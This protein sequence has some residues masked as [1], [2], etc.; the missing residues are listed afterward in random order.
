MNTR[1][2]LI[3]GA[4]G[5]VGGFCLQALCDN[6]NYSEVTALVRK[7]ILKTHRKLKVITSSFENLQN[8]L[9]DIQAHDVYCCLGTTIK[10][11]E[12]QEAFKKIDHTLVVSVAELMRKQG[13]EQF[14]IISAMGAD[15]KSK[16]FYNRT[17][18]EMEEDLKGVGYPCLRI[19]RPS[20]LLGQREEFRLAEKIGIILAPIIKPFLIGSLKKY[21]PIDAKAVA[22]FMVNSALESPV[23]GVY[24]YESDMIDQNWKDN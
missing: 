4:T 15:S 24:V 23:S 11:A 17:K 20:L 3:V 14:V 12:S 7:P 16:V 21:S 5:L 8:D 6:P 22:R 10:K 1:K 13:S 9:S 19:I 18:G 2:A